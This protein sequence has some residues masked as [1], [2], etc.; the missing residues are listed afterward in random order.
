MKHTITTSTGQ[1]IELEL[2]TGAFPAGYVQVN[3]DIDYLSPSGKSL[4]F[5]ALAD[6]AN[7]DRTAWLPVSQLAVWREG[8][9]THVVA[10]AWLKRSEPQV[11]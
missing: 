6:V 4:R 2:Y 5:V 10:K 8:S 11:F 1:N 3:A 9:F 7:G